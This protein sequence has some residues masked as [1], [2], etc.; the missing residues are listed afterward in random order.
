MHV[1][2]RHGLICV[3]S[4]RIRSFYGP[5]FPV[6]GLNTERYGVIETIETNRDYVKF[7]DKN[8][9]FF[10]Y[11]FFTYCQNLICCKK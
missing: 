7:W 11:H 2:E 6:Y 1:F 8:F 3:K 10:P 4:V 9:Y 5:H